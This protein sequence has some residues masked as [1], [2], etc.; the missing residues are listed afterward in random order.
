MSANPISVAI[1]ALR[2]HLHACSGQW[3]DR[4]AQV[5]LFALDA[6]VATACR[7]A[8]IPV[9][10]AEPAGAPGYARIGTTGVLVRRTLD[11]PGQVCIHSNQDSWEARMVQ[12]GEVDNRPQPQP[13]GGRPP[14]TDP[15]EDQ[16][17]FDV[18]KTRQYHTYEALA[19]ALGNGWTKGKV[20]QAL[21]RHRKRRK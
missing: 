6:K 14:D 5:V 12:L 4:D 8:G 16:R 10:P 13:G 7:A 1:E 19:K 18:W 9:P 20:R 15:R 11:R 21:D 17:V 3:L 2:D